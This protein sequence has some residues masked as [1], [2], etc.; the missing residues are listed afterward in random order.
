MRRHCVLTG[1]PPPLR[2]K[3]EGGRLHD[4]G[5]C[6]MYHS[7]RLGTALVPGWSTVL[8]RAQGL[9][10]TFELA[11]PGLQPHDVKAHNQPDDRVRSNE[12]PH[13]SSPP[14]FL[15]AAVP[16]RPDQNVSPG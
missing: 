5:T 3:T 7:C 8:P 15:K 12:C 13:R 2:S 11:L 9:E 16:P 14:Y 10:S 6:G 4:T 1:K